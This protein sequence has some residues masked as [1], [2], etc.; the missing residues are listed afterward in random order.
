[1]SENSS[2]SQLDRVTLTV[3]EAA[4]ML[5]LSKGAVYEAAATGAIPSIRV[6]RRILI[7]KAA[8]NRLLASASQSYDAACKRDQEAS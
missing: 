7:P 2:A 1:M 3:L 8:L 6:G 4:Q 5:G